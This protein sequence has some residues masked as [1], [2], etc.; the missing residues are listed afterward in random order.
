[1][2]R[3]GEKRLA[4]RRI[5][6][7]ALGAADQPEIELVLRGAQVGDE[8][9]VIALRIVDQ[10]AGVDLEELR[11]EQARRVGQVRARAALDLREI[12]LA[13]RGFARLLAGGVLLL[14]GADQLLLSHGTVEPAEIAFYLAQITDFV[15]ELHCPITNRNIYIAICNIC[16][17]RL[18]GGRNTPSCLPRAEDHRQ[19]Y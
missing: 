11:E 4:E 5:A 3:H 18:F 10:I 12:R 16:Q 14:D 1:M 6:T 15:A 8:L 7:E 2:V 9:R 17:M 19:V 13:D